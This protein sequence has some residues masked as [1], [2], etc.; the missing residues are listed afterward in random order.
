MKIKE[1]DSQH[2]VIETTLGDRLGWMFGFGIIIV[3]TIIVQI[4]P[5]IIARLLFSV[6]GIVMMVITVRPIIGRKIV[7]DKFAQTI[8]TKERTFLLISRQRVIP[9]LDV[10]SVVIDYERKIY[11]GG[12][13]GGGGSADAWRVYIDTDKKTKID[14]KR[15]KT[16]MLHLASEISKFIGTE[17]VDNSAKR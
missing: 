14:H 12:M 17:L 10:R 11:Q 7:I 4:I 15:N 2:M 9:F 6:F 16:N 13:M 3:W 5:D 1:Q 8:I